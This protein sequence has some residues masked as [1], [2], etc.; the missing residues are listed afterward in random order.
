MGNSLLELS[1]KFNAHMTEEIRKRVQEEVAQ[2]RGGERALF[3]NMV[4][5][6][7]GDVKQNLVEENSKARDREM[8]TRAIESR[9]TQR[10]L[11]NSLLVLDVALKGLGAEVTQLRAEIRAGAAPVIDLTGETETPNYLEGEGIAA[12]V[13]RLEVID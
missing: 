8:L 9:N 13:F 11:Q 3:D 5:Q 7:V 4:A 12:D 2:A 6:F 1:E 10:D